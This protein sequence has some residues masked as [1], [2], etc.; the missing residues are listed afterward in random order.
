M[1]SFP[2]YD[3]HGQAGFQHL[4]A[5]SASLPGP[6][7]AWTFSRFIRGLSPLGRLYRRRGL[8]KRRHLMPSAIGRDHICP[9]MPGSRYSSAGICP[10]AI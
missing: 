3:N 7:W 8:R 6:G 9:H 4:L 2:H 5:R 10:I 1:I